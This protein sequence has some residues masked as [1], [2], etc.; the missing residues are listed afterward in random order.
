MIDFIHDARQKAVEQ[1]VNR[2]WR[3]FHTPNCEED[4]KK[5]FEHLKANLSADEQKIAQDCWDG[6]ETTLQSKQNTN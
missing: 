2:I 6:L 4:A 1:Q 5:E 3:N